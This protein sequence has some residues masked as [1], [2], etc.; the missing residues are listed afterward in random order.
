MGK[1]MIRCLKTTWFCPTVPC[2]KRNRAPDNHDDEDDEDDDDDE[3]QRQRPNLHRRYL[4]PTTEKKTTTTTVLDLADRGSVIR[5][6]YGSSTD[7]TTTQT[8]AA[9][10]D[11]GARAVEGAYAI[12]NTHGAYDNY[13]NHSHAHPPSQP[14]PHY[15]T[16][17]GHF[18][19]L[20]HS[21]S[22]ER[23]GERSERASE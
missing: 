22:H 10:A 15:G 14:P 5:R 18:E 16:K 13:D 4:L 1:W 9:E 17:P 19:T 11:G 20:N 12:S 2:S 7:P 3:E 23:G 6:H 21:L 8:Q